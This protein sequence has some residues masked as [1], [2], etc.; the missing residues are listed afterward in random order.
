MAFSQ[1]LGTYG[2]LSTDFQAVASLLVVGSESTEPFFQK[3]TME[4]ITPRSIRF[5][6]RY[7]YSVSRVSMLRSV[8]YLVLTYLD[9]LGLGNDQ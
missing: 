8:M 4:N 1:R 7:Q 6:K 5:Q 2:D 3:R 9:P